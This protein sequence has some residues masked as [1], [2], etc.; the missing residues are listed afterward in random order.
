MPK[1]ILLTIVL[2]T[3][4]ILIVQ[5]NKSEQVKSIQ[6]GIKIVT[7]QTMFERFNGLEGVELVSVNSTYDAVQKLQQGEV[8]YIL[9]GRVPKLSEDITRFI[10]LEEGMSFLSNQERSILYKDL[11]GMKIYTDL[12]IQNQEFK[13]IEKVDNVYE[14]LDKGVVITSWE[15]TDYEKASIAHIL[16]ED[17]TRWKDSRTPVLYC[18]GECDNNL[19]Q[20]LKEW[21]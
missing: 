17:G 8:K 6:E 20:I 21:K 13:N 19:I 1:Y 18:N 14:Y 16:K 5:S 9:S 12:D 3:L 7:C 11:I 10:I 15:N 2:I 4:P